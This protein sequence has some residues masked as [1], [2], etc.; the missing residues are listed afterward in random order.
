ME[1]R[2]RILVVDD[3][4]D[5]LDLVRMTLADLYDVLTLQNPLEVYEILQLFEPD[6]LILDIMMPKVTGFQIIEIL[7]KSP[8]FS[9][10]PIMILSAKDSTREIKYGYKLGAKLYLTKP[11]QPERLK[12]NVEF[13]LEQ[14]VGAPR[15]KKLSVQAVDKQIHTMRS[16]KLGLASFSSSLLSAEAIKAREAEER[17]KRKE[18][19]EEK[20]HD[21]WI[22]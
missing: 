10:I 8:A 12:K 4:V 22:G 17:K 3:H 7:Q 13:L 2:Y 1:S 11:F 20:R 14:F 6:L 18:E 15:P 19:G 9:R 5:T 21:R 16:Y